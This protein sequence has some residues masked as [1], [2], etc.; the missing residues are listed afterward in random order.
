MLFAFL[1]LCLTGL[2][3][4]LTTCCDRDDLLKLAGNNRAGLMRGNTP[5]RQESIAWHCSDLLR[6]GRYSDVIQ[7]LQPGVV[8]AETRQSLTAIH[9]I[10]TEREP[11]SVKVIDAQKFRREGVEITNIVLDYEFPSA[12][13]K[14]SSDT[15]LLPA[16]WV[17]VTFS[18][19]STEDSITGIHAVTSEQSIEAI[20]AFTFKNKGV[21]QYTAFAAGI[22][23]N[24]FA[25][26]AITLCV[27][28]KIGLKKWLWIVLMLF[29]FILVSVNWTTGDWSFDTVSLG[30]KL[31]PLPANL[32]C[33]AYGPWNLKLGLPIAAIVFVLYRK[34]FEKTASA[35]AA[36]VGGC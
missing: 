27:T 19:R 25:V 13:K 36:R 31:P 5:L 16:K 35:P 26:Y 30:F 11:V 23:L 9:D 24:A 15:E 4:L 22:L 32:V 28:A 7:L 3:I 6:E 17:F 21:S 2:A 18:I 1:T 29:T 33:S 8:G 20:N 34:K 10:L 12:V 14:T